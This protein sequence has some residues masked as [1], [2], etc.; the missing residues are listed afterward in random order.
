MRGFDEGQDALFSLVSMEKRIPEDHPLRSILT[1]LA[2]VC[3][4]LD[5]VF[6]TLYV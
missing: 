5:P 3:E 2:P 6:H 4:R 1:L